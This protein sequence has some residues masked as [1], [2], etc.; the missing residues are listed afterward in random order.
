MA[1]PSVIP[2]ITLPIAPAWSC[3]VTA[4][5]T[6]A[7]V[8]GMM[9]AEAM[10]PSTRRPIATSKVG[11]ATI[12]AVSTANRISA[13]NSSRLRSIRSEKYPNIGAAMA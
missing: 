12:A 10:P 4:S 6:I 9:M 3:S 1:I 8:V 5:A 11:A 2:S 13:I 7:K